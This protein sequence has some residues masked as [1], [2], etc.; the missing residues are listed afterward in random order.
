MDYLTQDRK[1]RLEKALKAVQEKD[2]SPDIIAALLRA[3][4]E[5]DKK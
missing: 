2:G 1:E 4:K 3:L 5:Y